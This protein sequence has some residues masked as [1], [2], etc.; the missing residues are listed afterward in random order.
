MGSEQY[1][2]ENHPKCGDLAGPESGEAQDW[3][4]VSISYYYHPGLDVSP[5]CNDEEISRS[6]S[7]KGAVKLGRIDIAIEVPIMAESVATPCIDHL[8]NTTLQYRK[9]IKIRQKQSL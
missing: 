5:F 1:V 7:S 6:E 8:I 2:K 3:I 9:P 4:H